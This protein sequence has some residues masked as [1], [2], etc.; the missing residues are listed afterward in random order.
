M[1]NNLPSLIYYSLNELEFD[2]RN[3]VISFNDA[4]L[5]QLSNS[6]INGIKNAFNSGIMV[7][8]NGLLYVKV[9]QLRNLLRTA[10][11]AHN[12]MW[13]DGMFGYVSPSRPFEVGNE[14]CISGPDFCALL[15]ARISSTIGK[16]NIYL[17]YV[18]S[19]Y[20]NITSAAFVQ[21]LRTA[22]LIDVDQQRPYLKAGRISK[23][24]IA[25][26]EFTG[27]TINDANA[28]EFAHI[29]SVSTHLFYAK[30]I[31][32][33]VIIKKELHRMLTRLNIHSFAG[34]LEFCE[35]R[36]FSTRWAEDFNL[37]F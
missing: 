34:M 15:D 19:I 27:E 16:Q 32:N 22:F 5:Q 1:T 37:P 31:D 29:M 20:Q 26:C 30:N 28:F 10:N 9:S 24:G 18:R 17:K 2:V 12:S 6:H 13:Q 33:G 23:Y 25:S 14:I 3:Q 36:K 21:E 11:G 8:N 4:L 7:L 35:E